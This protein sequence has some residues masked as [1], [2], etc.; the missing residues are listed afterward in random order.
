MNI[1]IAITAKVLLL[2][3]NNFKKYRAIK[4]MAQLFLSTMK[5]KALLMIFAKNPEMGKVKTR[6]AKTIGDKNALMVYLKLLEHTHQ[7]AEKTE[8]EKA[9][10]FSDKLEEFD[11]LDY[12]KFPKYLQSGSDL[13]NRMENAFQKSFEK[14]F[15][16][17]GIIGS[18]CYQLTSKIL[19]QAYIQL[20]DF[21]VVI[22]PAEDGGYYFL[23]T[24]K[25]Y[26]FLFQNKNW[27]QDDVLLDTILDC[28]KNNLTYSLLE[29]LVDIDTEK[30]LGELSGL[31]V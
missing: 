27:S 12:Y 31:I 5:E 9:V 28:K 24:K 19:E 1:K 18:D 20:N 2:P 30:D 7:V 8:L 21:D 23:G 29:T 4:K 3:R 25:H 26:P 6:L 15:Q 22:G 11:L 16:K 13:G 14:G 10:F 17:V